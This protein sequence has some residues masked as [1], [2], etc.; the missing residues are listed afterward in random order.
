MTNK[1]YWI[2]W[3]HWVWIDSIVSIVPF[4]TSQ[5]ICQFSWQSTGHN[6]RAQP[7][8]P[9]VFIHFNISFDICLISLYDLNLNNWSQW[10]CHSTIVKHRHNFLNL[11]FNF[12]NSYIW[13]KEVSSNT[14]IFTR[15]ISRTFQFWT[16]NCK[17]IFSTIGNIPQLES[18]ILNKIKIEK[19][20]NPFL[21]TIGKLNVERNSCN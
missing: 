5:A 6:H 1:E 15:Y 20:E 11:S 19:K 21:P 13:C 14:R 2:S 9:F 4:G 12:L 7:D 16:T 17:K 8:S 18:T 3:P 10:P